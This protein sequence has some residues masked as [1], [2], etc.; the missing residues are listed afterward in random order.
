[1]SC[2]C[3]A[4]TAEEGNKT[5]SIYQGKL[6][7]YSSSFGNSTGCFNV[8][9]YSNFKIKPLACPMSSFILRSADATAT[10]N[11]VRPDVCDP[12]HYQS[13][14]LF[15]VT[16]RSCCNHDALFASNRG[17]HQQISNV[18]ASASVFVGVIGGGESYRWAARRFRRVELFIDLFST[19][20]MMVSRRSYL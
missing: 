6:Q 8:H 5:T 18:F 9:Y 20:T 19:D 13:A 10:A 15:G 12:D 14:Q 3:M 11:P 16:Q 7:A 2:L 1:M 17:D 4:F